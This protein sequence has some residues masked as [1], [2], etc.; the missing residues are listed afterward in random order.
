MPS[1]TRGLVPSAWRNDPPVRRSVRTATVCAL[2]VASRGAGSSTASSPMQL[3]GPSIVTVS[4]CETVTSPSSSTKTSSPGSPSRHRHSPAVNHTSVPAR[5]SCARSSG[6]RSS[7]TPIDRS[8]II[9]SSVGVP[10]HRAGRQRAGVRSRFTDDRVL[11]RLEAIEVLGA[12]LVQPFEQVE[13]GRAQVGFGARELRAQQAGRVRG[14]RRVRDVRGPGPRSASPLSRARR[15]SDHL[16]HASRVPRPPP[17]K[18]PSRS[19]SAAA[20][21]PIIVRTG[22]SAARAH[23]RRS[24]PTKNAAAG[25]A[26]RRSAPTAAASHSMA[27]GTPVR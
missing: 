1:D 21:S 3:P 27:A 10:R 24:S 18:S 8:A 12:R 14:R 2:T 23:R 13:R 25:S 20:T 19:A 26:W 5:A 6:S 4:P 15:R 22:V 9:F 11:V 17:D 16:E 7:K